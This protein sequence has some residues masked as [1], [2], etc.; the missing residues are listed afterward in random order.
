MHECVSCTANNDASIQSWDLV[1]I[2]SW[3]MSY[4]CGV[5]KI[6]CNHAFRN[7]DTCAYSADGHDF[8]GVLGKERG[9]VGVCAEDNGFGEERAP[10]GGYGVVAF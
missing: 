7:V 8:G 9:R 1:V 4:A 3:C 5:R 6:R 10:R 2:M